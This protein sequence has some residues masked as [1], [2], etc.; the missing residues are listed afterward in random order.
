MH[1]PLKIV[2]DRVLKMLDSSEVNNEIFYLDVRTLTELVQ[3]RL[4]NEKRMA[5]YEG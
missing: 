2:N 1:D 5:G 3:K 4:E